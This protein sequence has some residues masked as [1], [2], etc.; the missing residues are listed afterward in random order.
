MDSR[1]CSSNEYLGAIKEKI[2]SGKLTFDEI[3]KR[4]KAEVDA[5]LGKPRSRIDYAYLSSCQNLLDSVNN[6]KMHVSKQP[7]Y[8]QELIQRIKKTERKHSLRRR[9]MSA[10]FA[11]MAILVLIV[12]GDRLFF[13]EWLEGNSTED[14]QQYEIAGQVV[15]PGLVVSGIA[16]PST[17]TREVTT[18]SM[19]EV[20]DV[21]GFTPLVPTWY[22]DGW[23][24]HSYYAVKTANV[25]RFYEALVSD[26]FNNVIK[27]EIERFNDVGEA[28]AFFEQ[29]NHGRMLRCNGWDVYVTENTDE[30]V[31]VWLDENCCYS[32]YGP[33]KEEDLLKIIMSIVKGE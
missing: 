22:P 6:S 33:L 2:E 1:D 7:Q 25:Q 30:Y 3:C 17:E 10:A 28:G 26:N 5:E 21:L 20:V 16:D 24:R 32:L 15:D 14:M 19:E 23:E 18:Q 13:R 31:A 12:V 8:E 4:L 29:D 9:A 11:A 27:F